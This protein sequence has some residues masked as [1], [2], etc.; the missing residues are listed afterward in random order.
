MAE[1]DMDP[2]DFNPEKPPAFQVEQWLNTKAP[3]TLAGLKGKVV[4]LV[5]FQML[6]PGCVEHAL[7]QVRRLARAFRADDVTVIGLHTVFEHHKVMT[8]DA[9]KAFVMEYGWTF[10]IGIDAPNG[11]NLPRTMAAYEMQGTPTILLFDRQG[12]LRRHYLGQVDDIRLGAEIMA[13]AVEP[14]DAPRTASMAIEQAL[15]TAL[16]DPDAGGGHA[17]HHHGHD[18]C[19]GGHHHDGPAHEHAH[20][21]AHDRAQ[22]HD[23]AHGGGCGDPGCAC[24]S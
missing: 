7:P 15:A 14:A 17:H 11:R 4:V 13:L 9:L 18:A 21:H 10:P 16:V 23:H 3:L 12:R 5:A 24:R 6:C 22:G 20:H 2:I 19:C 8:A 1:T